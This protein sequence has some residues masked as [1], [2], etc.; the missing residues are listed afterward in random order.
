MRKFTKL[1]S[2]MALCL[3]GAMTVHAEDE[4]VALT[5]DMFKTWN[6]YGADAVATGDANV[7]F[8]V[9]N[10]VEIS[11]GGMV[12]GTSSVAYLTYAD[13]TG[14]LKLIIE[15]TVGV[16]LRVLMNRQES[17]SGPLT[18]KNLEIGEGGSVE[19]DLTGFGYVHLNAIKLGW[20]SP[21]G[22]I[23]AIT[24]IKPADPLVIPKENLKA[25]IN[26]GKLK[27]SVGKT[28][29]SFA[30]LTTAIANGEE[31]L[32]NKN[33]TEESLA[34]A[35]KAINDAIAGL[36][37]AD[38]Y[39]NLTA[40]MYKEWDSNTMPTVGTSTGC[41]YVLNESTGQPYGDG[42]V[43]YKKFADI[44]EY[45]AMHLVTS[46]TPRVMLNRAEPLEPGTD[47][48]DANGGAY[49]EIK[50][51]AVDGKTT[52]DLTA[53]PYV[54]LN[55]IKEPNWGAKININEMLLYRTITVGSAGY[56][57]FGSLDKSVKLNGVTGYA[58]VYEGGV[59]KLTEVTGVPA[60]KG[61]IIEAA[62]GEYAP[63][64]DVESNDIT[65][66]LLVSNGTVKGDG[67]TI[68][69]LANGTKGVGFYKVANGEAVPAGK[70]YL[71]I[72]AE[73]REFIGFGGEATGIKMVENAAAN[74]GEVFNLA[75]QRVAQPTKGLYI[76][77]G[78]KVV[79]K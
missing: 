37:L 59:L 61:V 52:I 16:Q 5:A 18:E 4:E 36:K 10:D 64:F 33:A 46:G 12:C 26:N 49:V 72:A 38:G 70:A 31:E 9:G 53:Y 35:T 6:G 74:N 60:G 55:A 63:T 54:H 79:I 51:A 41:A 58:A 20:S 69:A 34:A 28:E 7:D 32:A 78:K 48:Y 50:N 68:F 24:M 1:L 25:A 8:N 43:Y 11:G 73:A 62:A 65:S 40:G 19:L 66:D 71:N 14:N 3:F 2:V 29:A 75:G 42:S 67:V 39:T 27:N 15:G 47:G 76:M 30:A 77:N 56:A 57:T 23:N 21:A 45:S 13:L 17:D 44:S 22:K